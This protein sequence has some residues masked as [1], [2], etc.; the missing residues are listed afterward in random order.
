MPSWRVSP[1]CSFLG[2]ANESPKKLFSIRKKGILPSVRY[3]LIVARGWLLPVLWDVTWLLMCLAV[4][5]VPL[6]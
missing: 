5:A 6:V 4:G 2:K 1:V 3:G